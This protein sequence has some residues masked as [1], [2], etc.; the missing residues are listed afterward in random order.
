MVL[1]PLARTKSH[2]RETNSFAS[3]LAR[4]GLHC[5]VTSREQLEDDKLVELHALIVESTRG[6]NLTSV[7]K[8]ISSN[9]LNFTEWSFYLRVVAVA[10]RVVALHKHHCKHLSASQDHLHVALAALSC[11]VNFPTRTLQVPSNR[12]IWSQTKGIWGLQKV[13]GGSRKH[14]NLHSC[15]ISS[16]ALPCGCSIP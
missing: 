14:F 6:V 4:T 16:L 2:R 15:C 13:D 3:Y 7:I 1:F 8:Q 12:G 9:F 11:S 10:L 5:W